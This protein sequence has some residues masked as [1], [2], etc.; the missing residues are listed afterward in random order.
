MRT[1]LI[2]LAASFCGAL[3]GQAPGV[4][5]PPA[6]EAPTGESIATMAPEPGAVRPVSTASVSRVHVDRP[7]A[8]GPLWAIGTAWKASFDGDGMTVIP[9][10]GSLAPR[11]FPLRVDLA[12]VQVGSATLSLSRGEPAQRGDDVRTDRGSVTEVVTMSLEQLE[13]SW[14]FD[15]LPAREAIVAE[16]RMSGEYSVS[17]LEQGLRFANEHGRIDYTKAVAVDAKGASLPLAIVWAGDRA[18]ITIPQEFVANAALPIVLD[19]VYNFWFGLGS[20]APAGQIQSQ[21]DVASLQ[22]GSG[23][24]LMVWRRQWSL[25]D[26]DVWGLMFDA[27]LGLV[28]T[29]FQIDFTADDWLKISCA[30]NTWAQNF[31]VVGEVRLGI[32]HNIFGRIINTA[33]VPQPVITI[34]RDGIVGSPGNNFDPDVGGDPYN[35]SSRYTVVWHK[36][37]LLANDIVMKQVAPSGSLVTTLPI[38]IANST[39][40]ERNPSISKCCGHLPGSP[41]WLV[42]FQKTKTALPYDQDVHGRFVDFSGALASPEFVIATTS[43]EHTN[44]VS[45]SPIDHNGIRK[46]PVAWETATAAG[47]PREVVCGFVDQAGQPLIFIN[48]GSQIPGADDWDPDVD[49]D[50]TRVTLTY[51][52]GQDD[53]EVATYSLVNTGFG[54]REDA[55]S[56]ILQVG[57]NNCREASI[58]AE[59]SGG[60][61]RSTRYYVGY[62]DATTNTLLLVAWGGFEG[63]LPFFNYRDSY[64][65][66]NVPIM[67]SGSS[68]IGE[69]L[70]VL[71]DNGS[72]LAAT[73]FNGPDSISLGLLGCGCLQGIANGAVFGPSNLY[74]TVP[75]NTAYV[76]VDLSVQGLSLA[77]P[78]CLSLFTL[79]DIVDFRVR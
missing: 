34:E 28:Q 40:D 55:R 67:A 11:N 25:T 16:V 24:T 44:P 73:M 23:R 58:V 66:S 8:D 26:Q 61:G 6:L 72:P 78:E 3:L 43:N 9:F 22:G 4:A 65:S 38:V 69:Q 56:G 12:S 76:G 45:G 36:A 57:A 15:A 46:W 27:G 42:S 30:S 7:T 13:Q 68:V 60:Y 21:S 29:D 39:V 14:V 53:F 5:E 19:P 2:V 62:T 41:F 59:Y 18:R 1:H 47:Q 51:S 33:G 31:L 35:A 17:L 79:S 50:G 48:F 54:F 10:F 77:S 52:I 37:L 75:N 71:V 70:Q 64:C 49:S 32:Q 63:G 20:A 74:W